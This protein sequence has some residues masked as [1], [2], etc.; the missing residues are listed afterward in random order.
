VSQDQFSEEKEVRMRLVN[1]M[2]HTV[3]MAS[4]GGG[5]SSTSVRMALGVLTLAD[6]VGAV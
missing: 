3:T 4:V 5:F 2:K 6:A 1:W